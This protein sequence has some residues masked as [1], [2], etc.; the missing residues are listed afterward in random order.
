ME[1][2]INVIV[3]VFIKLGQM[4]L[5]LRL[6]EINVKVV[7]GYSKGEIYSQGQFIIREEFIVIFF[8]EGYF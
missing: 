4:R 6:Q 8:N 7:G 1:V 5:Q 2:I 3:K